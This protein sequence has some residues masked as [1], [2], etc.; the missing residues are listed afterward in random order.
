MKIFQ[1]GSSIDTPE[2]SNDLDL[3]IV[4]DIPV[5]M[6]LYTEEQWEDFKTNGHSSKGHRTVIHPPKDKGKK[7]LKIKQ[8]L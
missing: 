1:I 5:D 6:C 8:L 7:L 2:I 4:S 3:I